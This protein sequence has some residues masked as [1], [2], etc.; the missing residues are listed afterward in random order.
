MSTTTPTTAVAEGAGGGL[1]KLRRRLSKD[2]PLPPPLQLPH[3][4]TIYQQSVP[5]AAEDRSMYTF[6]ASQIEGRL[7]LGPLQIEPQLFRPSGKMQDGTT[8]NINNDNDTALPEQLHAVLTIMQVDPE[9]IPGHV[10]RNQSTC[11]L[12][13]DALL[14]RI[15]ISDTGNHTLLYYTA[16]IMAFFGLATAFRNGTANTYV[17]CHMGIS[18][19]V[20]GTIMFL[21]AA[22]IIKHIQDTI[23]ASS[24]AAAADAISSTESP[25]VPSTV[26]E[27]PGNGSSVVAVAIAADTDPDCNGGC[28]TFETAKVFV[29]SKRPCAEPQN[30]IQFNLDLTYASRFPYWCSMW[31]HIIVGTAKDAPSLCL[32]V[33]KRLKTSRVKDFI[34]L[35]QLVHDHRGHPWNVL[36]IECRYTTKPVAILD[37]IRKL[38]DC[39]QSI[40]I[41][42]LPCKSASEAGSEWISYLPY[43]VPPSSTHLLLRMYEIG[44]AHV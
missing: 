5:D 42:T 19:S 15:P 34:T 17:H 18:R 32:R 20:C 16:E 11:T 8:T 41:T 23:M 36:H 1:S 39:F 7:W 43:V 22:D 31:R 12:S 40:L 14:W 21:M 26:V 38:Q 10:F 13:A 3:E 25:S 29:Q 37:A 9:D 24:T 35:M 33:T 6:V 27:E 30:N 44:R 28:Y 4:A 2:R